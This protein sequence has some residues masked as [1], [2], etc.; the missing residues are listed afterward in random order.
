[1]TRKNSVNDLVL[2]PFRKNRGNRGS[3]DPR[4][5]ESRQ[6]VPFDPTMAGFD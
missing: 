6:G 4:G 1:M 3:A 5:P 2:W